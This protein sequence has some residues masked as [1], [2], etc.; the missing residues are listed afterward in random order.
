MNNKFMVAR[1]TFNVV[2]F[3]RHAEYSNV[4]PRGVF[5]ESKELSNRWTSNIKKLDE[6]IKNLKYKQNSAN[7]TG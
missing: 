5:V 6:F 4:V 7:G 3:S 1:D 2:G